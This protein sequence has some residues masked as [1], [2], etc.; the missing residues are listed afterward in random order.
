MKIR[1]IF[2]EIAS[3]SSSNEKMNILSKYKDN[4][5]LEK[6]LYLANSKRVNF[7][8]KKIPEYIEDVNHIDNFLSHK[9]LHDLSLLNERIVTG[10]AA[11]DH[12]QS[13]LSSLNNDDAYII[14]RIIDKNC[15]IGMGTSNINKIFPNLI[16]KTGYMG[17]KPFTEE[18]A[19]A[20]FD[21]GR[22]VRSDI[23]MDGRY[24]NGF[25][26]NGDVQLVTRQGEL[27]PVG[28]ATFLK[29]LSELPDGVYN[30][31]LTIDSEPSRVIANGIIASIVDIEGKRE[32]RTE[33]ETNKKI[34]NF[35]KKHGEYQS[36][37]NRIVYTVWDRIDI[38]E[39]FNSTSKIKSTVK[40]DDRRK[41][42]VEIINNSYS[43]N[44]RIVESKLVYSYA[45]A[46][47]HFQQA[48]NRG[49][50]GTILKDIYGV[51]KDGKDKWQIKMKLEIS[52][53]LRII[54]FNYGSGKNY[55]VI[56]SLTCVSKCGILKT[57]PTG[58]DENTMKLIEENQESLLNTIVEVKSCGI[59]NNS[60]GE[61]S[62][63]HPVF[64]LLRPDKDVADT[65]EEIKL[66][67]NAAKSLSLV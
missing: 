29:E 64:M 53:D 46:V 8:I 59:S 31:E 27:T 17:A 33:V 34:S 2:D 11:I 10:Q 40:Y 20:L 57:K 50:E 1:E 14:E 15:K 25:V 18:L 65:F 21:K 62:M 56:S 26:K 13:I 16:E 28:D 22:P 24:Q 49:L 45:E 55:N 32:K 41:L 36:F 38:D 43:K 37:I 35:T 5:L 63:L 52:V 7:Y 39:Y 54:G 58:I 23:K 4:K 6:V 60:K 51:W 30:G 9:V 48:L 67:E 19:R 66:I 3:E 44:I 12:L 47:E 61:Y 42:L